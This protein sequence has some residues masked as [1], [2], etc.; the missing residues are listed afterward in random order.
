MTPIG[1]PSGAPVASELV[2]ES[3]DDGGDAEELDEREAH[4]RV[5]LAE[6][7]LDERTD[8]RRVVLGEGVEHIGEA[9]D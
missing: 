7:L 2:A 5:V 4:G 6:A 9:R 8:E 3:A 1:E